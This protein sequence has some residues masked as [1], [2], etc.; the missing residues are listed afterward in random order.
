LAD[1]Q[2]LAPGPVPKTGTPKEVRRILRE[3]EEVSRLD[4]FQLYQ[5]TAGE[6]EARATQARQGM[7]AE[8]RRETAVDRTFADDQ[9]TRTQLVFRVGEPGA[10]LLATSLKL[11]AEATPATSTK[12][13]Q[14]GKTS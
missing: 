1:A 8:E 14:G 11:D 7:T 6:A 5:R 4:N 10:G 12:F 13:R 3:A 2:R 9:L